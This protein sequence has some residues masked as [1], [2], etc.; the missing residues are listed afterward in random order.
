[1]TKLED[2]AK[3][4][5]EEVNATLHEENIRIDE[6]IKE[7][8]ELKQQ[9]MA[10]KEQEIANQIKI[11]ENANALKD[12]FVSSERLFLLSLKERLG[13][14]FEG[15]NS[16]AGNVELRLDITIK[17]LEFLLASVEDRL[18]NLPK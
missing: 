12:D 11:A 18:S 5:I 17:F 6:K 15:L 4:A 2:I 7:E 1:M 16:D 14:L 9:E 10:L 3:L 13:V 8:N